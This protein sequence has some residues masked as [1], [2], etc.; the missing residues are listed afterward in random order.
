MVE[1]LPDAVEVTAEEVV[2]DPPRRESS[3]S[4]HSAGT[5]S[6]TGRSSWCAERANRSGNTW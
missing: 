1:P 4:S 3:E 2:G 6:G 5:A